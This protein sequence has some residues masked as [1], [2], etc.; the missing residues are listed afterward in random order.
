MIQRYNYNGECWW[1]GSTDNSREHKYK[2][3]DIVRLFGHSWFKAQ[4]AL[5]RFV[6]GNERV[7]QGPKSKE[8]VF[9]SNLCKKCNGTRSQPFDRAY[10]KFIEYIHFNSSIIIATKQ[11][12]FSS[13][14]QSAWQNQR[15]NVIKYYVKH[16]CCR[17]AQAGV[18]IDPK[19][20]SYLNGNSYI[21]CLEM[22]FQIRE[23][24]VAM[25]AKLTD[26][27]IPEGSV[28]IGDGMA[29]HH[30]SSN[31]FSYFQ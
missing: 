5:L 26:E 15:D 6:E 3:T 4:N 20:L 10:D 17:L 18:L 30:Q 11:L 28:W 21:S 22:D 8:L 12:Q 24:I 2:R 25:E 13:I 14:F 27:Q 31:T 19:A 9:E 23:D 7:V 16:I 29:D 1:C